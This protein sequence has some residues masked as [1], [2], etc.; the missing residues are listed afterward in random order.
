MLGQPRLSQSIEHG[1]YVRRARL[2]PFNGEIGIEAA[3]F[4][5]G[6]FRLIHPA[7]KR[8]SGGQDTLVRSSPRP[9]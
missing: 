5:Q 9:R 8:V 1:R 7:R 2:Q 6:G 4:P 3:G